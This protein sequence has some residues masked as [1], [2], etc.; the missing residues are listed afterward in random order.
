M[1]TFSRDNA[2]LLR[3][4]VGALLLA[5]AAAVAAF[6][7]RGSALD[8]AIEPKHARPGEYVRLQTTAPPEW[9]R[10]LYTRMERREPGR[11]HP[12]LDLAPESE[13]TG[14][15]HAKPAEGDEAAGLA[16]AFPANGTEVLLLPDDVAAGR[17]R[18]RQRLLKPGPVERDLYVEFEVR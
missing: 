7:L 18:L 8:L 5:A 16:K 6:A 1:Q 15:P 11:W 9:A 17:Y 4:A 2:K 12:V 3:V 10:G 14:P 13:A